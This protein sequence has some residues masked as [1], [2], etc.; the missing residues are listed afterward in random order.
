MIKNISLYLLSAVLA[1]CFIG[2]NDNSDVDELEITYANVMVKSFS[3]EAN[4][5]VLNNLDSVFFSIDL[6]NA[7]IFNADSLP[8]GTKINRLIVNITTD[9]CSKVELH[10]PG[11]NSSDSI[12]DYINHPTDSVNFANGPVRLHLVSFDEKASRD[13]LIDVNVHKSIPDSMYWN[14]LARRSLPT[15]LTS[16]VASKTVRYNGNA[17]CLTTDTGDGYCIAS[18]SNPANDNWSYIS[19]NFG[20]VPSVDSFTATDD[21]LYILDYNG[22]LYSSVDGDS[23]TPEGVNW[24]SITGAYGKRLL[25]IRRLNGTYY[26]VTY[27]ATTETTVN[28]GFPIT[29]NSATFRFTTE[30]SDN[31]M[32]MIVGG[33]TTTG[34]FTGATWG[35]DGSVWA[36][37]S[38]ATPFNAE[39]MAV[40][41]YYCCET[42]SNTWVTTERSVFVAMGG[43]LADGALQRNVYISY[44]LGFHWKLADKKMQL[45]MDVPAT[46][47]AQA[48]VFNSINHAR[49]A[50]GCWHP[51]EP[52]PL[53]AGWML[54]VHPESRAVK[55][56]TEWDTPYV[57]MFGGSLYNGT[58]YNTVW[59]GVLNH[60]TFK[61]LQ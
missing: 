55:P 34:L 36:K 37:I 14:E 60:L 47:G 45:P 10:I 35:Y 11:V 48:L 20:F 29:G 8:Y 41:P 27:P 22:N 26:H 6:K 1:C 19:G 18:S 49:S 50:S 44:D 9:A 16:P 57:Y 33:R 25:G 40:F 17:V 56:I 12:I 5:K 13:Y 43:R 2:C 15:T 7:R 31:A 52:L 28:S 58:L 23:W 38:E 39:G 46:A 61:P 24:F 21:T 32:I 30:W 42:D 54:P 4:S 53:P 51:V 59:R 3:L